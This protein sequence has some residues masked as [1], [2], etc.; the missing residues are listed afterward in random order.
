[1]KHRKRVPS[2]LECSRNEPP[3]KAISAN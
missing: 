3:D 1:M 2:L